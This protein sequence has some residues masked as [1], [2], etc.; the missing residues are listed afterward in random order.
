MSNTIT[1]EFVTRLIKK[2]TE[3]LTQM[4]LKSRKQEIIEEITNVIYFNDNDGS[5]YDSIE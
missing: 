3:R 5:T 4:G 1:D 2:V